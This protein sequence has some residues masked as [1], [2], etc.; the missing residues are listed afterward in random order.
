MLKVRIKDELCV[1][2]G[3]CRLACPQVF[4]LNDRDG[5]AYVLTEEVDDIHADAL[6][7]A[8]HSCPEGA[9]EVN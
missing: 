3:M 1:G 4:Q 8:V 5:H 7:M 9:I 6:E 2:H